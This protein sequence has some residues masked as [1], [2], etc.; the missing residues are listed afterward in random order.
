M[1]ARD[2]ESADEWPLPPAWMWGCDKC[3]ELYKAMKRASEA[4]QAAREA[5]GPHVDCDPFDTVV[6]S[7]L[8]LGQHIAIQHPEDV[9]A[10]D[11]ECAKCTAP[12]MEHMPEQLVLQ[13]RARHLFIPPSIVDRL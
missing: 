2:P 4:A 11:P 12:E 13:H 5:S 10:R 3:T 9:P 6:T 1:D 8:R 7:Q